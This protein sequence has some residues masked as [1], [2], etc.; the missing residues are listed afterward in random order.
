MKF[1]ISNQIHVGARHV[2]LLPII[3]LLC[4]LFLSTYPLVAQEGRTF[5]DPQTGV[6]YTVEHYISANYPIALVF[7]PDGRLFYTEKVT[8]NVRVINADG[9]RQPEPVIN[10]P[11]SAIAERG[12]IGITLDPDYQANGMIWASHIT[13]PTARD[14]PAHNIVRFHEQDG[15]GSDPQIM[16]SAPL[17]NNA[18]IHH[19]GNLHFDEDGLLYFTLGNNE[20]HAHSQ[21]LTTPQGAIHRFQV[22]DD[23]LISADNN[24]FEDSTIYAYGLRNSFDFTLDPYSTRIFATE[25]GDACDD[26]VNLILP[27]FNYGAGPDYACGKTAAGIDLGR[28]QPPLLSFT[29]TIA[30]TGILVYDHEAIPEW[31]GDVFFCDWNFGRLHRVRLNERRNQVESTHIID[32]GDGQCRIDIAIGPEG[33]LYFSM[34]GEEG[35]A[36]YRLLPGDHP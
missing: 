14:Y 20:I 12:L 11:S 30:P 13:E 28:Y 34:V 7:A 27:G 21:D 6:T 29:P 9:L 24:P 19:G 36:I 26:E 3:F 31:G 17:E 4:T 8:G 5:T 33:G 15:I 25:N 16:F 32:L 22:T 2:S 35:G 10:L 1:A 18:L 23:G